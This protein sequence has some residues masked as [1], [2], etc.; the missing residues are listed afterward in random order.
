MRRASRLVSWKLRAIPRR[1][2]ITAPAGLPPRAARWGSWGSALR[3][4]LWV[5]LGLGVPTSLLTA[6]RTSGMVEG[7][8]RSTTGEP[9]PDAIV[10]IL[11]GDSTRTGS[12]GR[13]R[14]RPPTNT[15]SI[16]AIG[17]RRLGYR[18]A[19]DIVSARQAMVGRDTLI[20]EL[21]L[22]PQSLDPVRVQA[23]ADAA[24]RRDLRRYTWIQ[25]AGTWDAV[26]IDRD[27]TERGALWPSD[28]LRTIPGFRVSNSGG[29]RTRVVSTRG[30][31]APAIV[32]DGMPMRGWGIDD[33]PLNDLKAV[34][35]AR[36]LGASGAWML[37]G[38]GNGNCGVIALYTK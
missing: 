36:G 24:W 5:I 6:Q 27:L 7:I 12:D 17:A 38:A 15:Q 4:C 30:N 18:P 22:L 20:F 23:R 26:F 31:C 2:P 34:L 3:L 1:R 14:L 8:V 32:L 19:T 35:V 28:L 16:F 25:N 10:V 21:D 33:I 29:L 13:F 9:L 11:G 37:A